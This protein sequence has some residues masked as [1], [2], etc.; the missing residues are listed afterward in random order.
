MSRQNPDHR[1]AIQEIIDE[2]FTEAE[3]RLEEVYQTYFASLKTIF[4]R[5]WRH[6]RDIPAKFKPYDYDQMV[7]IPISLK[8]QLDPGTLEYAIHEL[9]EQKIDL[10]VFE[11]CFKNDDTG[12]PAFDPKIL[13]KNHPVCL[14]T[15]HGRFSS[16]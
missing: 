3:Q 14:F 2:H 1:I 11:N 5:H 12:A 13:L 4:S 9:V 6:K 15:L 10:S 16:H 7:M 8:E